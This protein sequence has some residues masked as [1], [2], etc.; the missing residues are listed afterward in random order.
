MFSTVDTEAFS[1]YQP[2]AA[3]LEQRRFDDETIRNI[4]RKRVA[5]SIK[6]RKCIA[7]KEVKK[8]L[9]SSGS[10][11]HFSS[12]CVKKICRWHIFSIRSRRLCRRSSHLVLQR[13]AKVGRRRQNKKLPRR[14]AFLLRFIFLTLYRALPAPPACGG[15]CGNHC[16]RRRIHS[17]CRCARPSPR[18]GA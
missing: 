2:A 17:R 12:R 6:I 9:V 18:Q 7:R 3:A 13:T 11:A 10:F 15:T 8:P 4:L 5:Y 1:T 16:R 14:A